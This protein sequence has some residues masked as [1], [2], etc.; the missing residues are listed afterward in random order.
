MLW[1]PLLFSLFCQLSTIPLFV[2]SFVVVIVDVSL[3][4]VICVTVILLVAVVGVVV[5]IVDVALLLTISHLRSDGWCLGLFVFVLPNM[6][7]P[8]LCCPTS[9]TIPNIDII[10]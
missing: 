5:I 10:Y 3:T 4:V 1:P 9:Q 8:V 7:G 2:I 6:F